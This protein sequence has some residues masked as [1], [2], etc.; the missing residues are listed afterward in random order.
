MSS[1]KALTIQSKGI[2][3]G[4][5]TIPEPL[6]GLRAIVAGASGMSGQHMIQVLAQSPQR[7]EKVYA[8][9]RSPPS[10][11]A[12]NT[13]HISID[14]LSGSED[15]ATALRD[16]GVV[17]DVVFF[18]SYV[19]LRPSQSTEA[20]A[21]ALLLGRLLQN[22]LEA[23]DLCSIV[24]QRILLQTGLK[25]Y[26]V[27]LGPVS[28]PMVE[29]DPRINIEANF[30]YTQEDILI[31]YCKTRMLKYNITH[32]SWILGA[33]QGSLMNIFYPLA[34]YASV[35]KYLKRPLLFPGDLVAWDKA[36]PISSGTLNSLFHEW[37]VLN[38]D[39]GNQSLNIWDG[40]D[41]T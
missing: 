14:L 4:L 20:N 37:L 39:A 12:E 2:F 3:H 16:N 9:S 29:S 19:Q 11:K 26:G 34:V 28:I 13:Q 30:Y 21:V 17:A 25:T 41:F 22:L 32:P 7:W 36:Q 5:P 33:V 27:H 15:I 1:P 40:S 8:V 18:F 38:P 23:L 10:V 6:K 24:P 35:Q 31:E